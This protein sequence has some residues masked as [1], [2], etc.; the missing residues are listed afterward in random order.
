[1]PI[2]VASYPMRFVAV[3]MTFVRLL[4][5]Q[6]L[7]G[8]G[9]VSFQLSPRWMNSKAFMFPISYRRSECTK[10]RESAYGRYDASHLITEDAET[11]DLPAISERRMPRSTTRTL[12]S[13]WKAISKQDGSDRQD[14][15][16]DLCWKSAVEIRLIEVDRDQISQ[17]SDLRGDGVSAL[18]YRMGPVAVSKVKGR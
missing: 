9:P 1:M 14:K 15:G 16:T 10:R 2:S 3:K 12:R 5:P 18:H 4:S 7:E 8:I 6:K 11:L 17:Q 13:L